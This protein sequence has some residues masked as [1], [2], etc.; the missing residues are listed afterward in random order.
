MFMLDFVWPIMAV[1][2]NG[3]VLNL[4]KQLNYEAWKG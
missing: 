2:L 1:N 4:I 3:Q